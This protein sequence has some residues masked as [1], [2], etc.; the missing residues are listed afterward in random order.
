[1]SFIILGAI[2]GCS[3]WWI[4]L[5]PWAVSPVGVAFARLA[6]GAVALL[7]AAALARTRP[8]PKMIGGLVVGFAGV[9]VVLGGPR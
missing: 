4:K 6:A 3:L 8:N 7:L 9:V 2:W 1:M 5:G